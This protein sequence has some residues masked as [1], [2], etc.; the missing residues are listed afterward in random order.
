MHFALS[1]VE[2]VLRS[3]NDF[4][5]GDSILGMRERNSQKISFLLFGLWFA[6]AVCQQGQSETLS[7]DK[8][9][10]VLN[11]SESE[12]QAGG[13]QK[14]VKNFKKSI[15]NTQGISNGNSNGDTS[16]IS[17]GN[18]NRN[19]SGNLITPFSERLS[20]SKIPKQSHPWSV[21]ISIST[22]TNSYEPSAPQNNFVSTLKIS[23]K[24][25]INENYSAFLEISGL[26]QLN[27]V[28]K[29][30]INNLV[31]GFQRKEIQ[32]SKDFSVS[33]GSSFILPTNYKVK[34]TTSFQGAM[35]VSVSLLQDAFIFTPL[36]V[37]YDLSYAKNFYEFT[38]TSSDEPNLSQEGDIGLTIT[39][40][41]LKKWELSFAGSFSAAQTYQNIFLNQFAL[42]ETLA[43][44]VTK[45]F[46]MV[47]GHTN[48]ADTLK[49]DGEESNIAF[50]DVKTSTF[51]GSLGFTF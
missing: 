39:K 46:S 3:L 10:K 47:L 36:Q 34:Q 1:K 42:S 20:Q 43:Y 17:N 4:S 18:S 28:K 13:P 9:P 7:S 29:S 30:Q 49:P 24:Y 51:F 48:K 22:L 5:L 12:Y 6:V 38:R 50:Y 44:K 8:A 32:I 26:Q 25:K 21:A 35:G 41:I 40:P 2:R 23:P 27:Q 37:S 45:K 33:G 14:L 16:G 31:F 11:R 19:T 15:K